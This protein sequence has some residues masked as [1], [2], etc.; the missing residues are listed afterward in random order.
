MKT[1]EQKRQEAK[2]RQAI[3]DSLTLEEKLA[4]ILTRRGQSAREIYRLTF[5]VQHGS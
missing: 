4:L 5:K 1:K 2:E 3:Y